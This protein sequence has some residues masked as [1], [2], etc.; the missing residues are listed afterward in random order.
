VAVSSE[1]AQIVPSTGTEE[2][3]I[4]TRLRR[5]GEPTTR[6]AFPSKGPLRGVK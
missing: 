2:P 1:R 6:P 5:H 4:E 3:R